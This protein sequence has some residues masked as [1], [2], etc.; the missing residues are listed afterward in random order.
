MKIRDFLK[1]SRFSRFDYMELPGA[2]VSSARLGSA[3][4]GNSWKFVFLIFFDFL[5]FLHGC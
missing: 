3:R 1:M 5:N 2:G 4:L